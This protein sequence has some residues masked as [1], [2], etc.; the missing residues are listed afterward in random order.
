MLIEE[1]IT[2]IELRLDMEPPFSLSGPKSSP[3]DTAT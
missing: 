2:S 1:K 3:S